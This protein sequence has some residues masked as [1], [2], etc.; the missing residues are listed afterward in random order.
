MCLINNVLP[1]VLNINNL[2]QLNKN[3]IDS[4]LVVSM[5]PSFMHFKIAKICSNIGRNLITASYLT[6]EIKKLNPEFF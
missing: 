3:I 1:I 2:D 6:P 4:Y 5:L